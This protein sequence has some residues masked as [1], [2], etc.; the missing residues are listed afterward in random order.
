LLHKAF[1]AAL[2]AGAV[3]TSIVGAKAQSDGVT[4]ADTISDNEVV[5]IGITFGEDLHEGGMRQAVKDMLSCYQ[6]TLGFPEKARPCVVWDVTLMGFDW[7]MRKMFTG[8]DGGRDP[9]PATPDLSPTAFQA[10]MAA[11]AN[12]AFPGGP[13]EFEAYAQ[14]AVAKI[15]DIATRWND[16]H[17]RK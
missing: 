16:T 11:F 8:L 9:G 1:C 3:L 2:V 14:G 12:P 5:H 15:I 13:Q 4:I 6:N 7:N 17:A 10:R